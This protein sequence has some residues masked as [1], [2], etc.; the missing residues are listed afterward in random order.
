VGAGRRVRSPA[1]FFEEELRLLG[2]E[3]VTGA[4]RGFASEECEPLEDL[5][6]QGEGAEILPFLEE[7]GEEGDRVPGA[8]WGN[9]AKDISLGSPGLKVEPDLLEEGKEVGERIRGEGGWFPDC[10]E[11]EGD[12]RTGPACEDLL[13]ANPFMGGVLVEEEKVS[14]CLEEKVAIP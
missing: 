14:P 11:E 1:K 3:R 7:G 2:E 13:V 12:W 4:D 9:C 6:G 8:P 10:R 5:P